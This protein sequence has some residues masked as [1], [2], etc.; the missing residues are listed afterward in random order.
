VGFD[1]GC[2]VLNGLTPDLANVEAR[3]TSLLSGMLTISEA[4]FICGS[5]SFEAGE[6]GAERAASVQLSDLSLESS[7]VAQHFR[8]VP[9]GFVEPQIFINSFNSS[10]LWHPVTIGTAAG[11]ILLPSFR[12]VLLNRVQGGPEILCA[13][14]ISAWIKAGATDSP[15]LCRDPPIGEPLRQ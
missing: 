14:S 11:I 5:P 3:A 13:V 15:G 1:R 7:V 12:N 8:H 4:V 2:E 10:A 9:E 6:S